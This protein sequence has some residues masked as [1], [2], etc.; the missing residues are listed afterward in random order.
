M[1]DDPK[2]TTQITATDPKIAAADPITKTTEDQSSLGDGGNAPQTVDETLGKINRSFKERAA[3][4]RAKELNLPYINISATP[5]NPDLLR[6]VPPEMA[7]A[8]S[9]MP[10]FRIGKKLRIAVTDPEKAETKTAI[11]TLQNAGYEV[12]LNIATADGI[13]EANKLYATNQYKVKT[14]ISTQLSE[15]KIKVYEEEIKQLAD[16]KTR[17]TSLSSEEAVYLINVGALKT[18]ASDIHYEPEEKF[19]RMR[20]RIDGVLHEIFQIEK[21]TYNN[22]VNQIKY[23]SKM[24][25]NINN[26]PQDGRYSF[27]VNE[28]KVDVRVSALPTEY[29]ETFVCR[30]L[31]SGRHL[32]TF[33][34]LG[35]WDKNLEK[36]EHLTK[37]SHGMILITGPTGSGK[38]TTLYTMLDKFNKPETKVI[39]LEDPIEYHL[40]GVSQSQINEKRGYDFSNGLRAILRQDPDVVMLGEIRDLETAETAAQAAL[41]GHVLLSTLHTNSA[42]ETVPRLVNIGLAPFMIA[43]ALNTIIAQRLVRKICPN[44]QE[45]KPVPQSEIDEINRMIEGMKLVQPTL[46]LSIPKEL[47][48]GKGCDI[49][50]QTGYKSRIAIVEIL[51]I[52]FEMKDLILNKAGNA[53]MIEAARRK[54]MLT[55]REDGILKVL[56]GITTLEEVHRVTAIAE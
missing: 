55:M 10:F 35:F 27:M 33:D 24:K 53:K 50:N 32:I 37:I 45:L 21:S 26:E 56:K 47:P 22:I 51:D 48:I 7:A 38:T 15:E 6:I 23:Q 34:E 54:G 18:G 41:T 28:R 31:D 39:T 46:E 49:C 11:Q 8:A 17:L 12:N 5:V 30:L 9:L 19:I 14:Q 3:I 52:D 36:I 40:P 25:L 43:P 13:L 44:C 42:L 29:G 16:L 1:P 4:Q 20:F 2:I